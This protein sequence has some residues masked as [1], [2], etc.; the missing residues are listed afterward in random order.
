MLHLR[1]GPR[2]KVKASH[3]VQAHTDYGAV[4]HHTFLLDADAEAGADLESLIPAGPG[5]WDVAARPA[6]DGTYPDL[7]S[8]RAVVVRDGVIVSAKAS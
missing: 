2:H 5:T 6:S 4:F 3:W 7:E 1:D 8:R